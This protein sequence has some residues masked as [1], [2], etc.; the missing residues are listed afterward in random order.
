MGCRDQQHS[1]RD[2]LRKPSGHRCTLSQQILFQNTW[3]LSTDTVSLT[4]LLFGAQRSLFPPAVLYPK[5]K[6]ISSRGHEIVA[7]PLPNSQLAPQRTQVC[8]EDLSAEALR[9]EKN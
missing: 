3:R 9:K 8:A 1:L 7:V 4:V 5:N 2:P 6:G